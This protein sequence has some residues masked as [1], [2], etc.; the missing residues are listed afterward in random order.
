[1]DG[2]QPGGSIYVVN[3]KKNPLSLSLVGP[4]SKTEDRLTYTG[5]KQNLL[6]T[7]TVGFGLPPNSL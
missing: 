3:N 4:R 1:M 7:T 5:G 2:L 6:N